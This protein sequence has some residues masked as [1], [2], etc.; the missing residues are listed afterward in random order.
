MALLTFC[1]SSALAKGFYW[2]ASN[3]DQELTLVA[4]MHLAS[5]DFYPLDGAIYQ[6]LKRSELLIL[7][8][9]DLDTKAS[10]QYIQQLGQLG[11]SMRLEE[12][13][14]LLQ[15][16]RAERIGNNLNLP[17]SQV[18]QVK[19]WLYGLI[20]TNQAFDQNGL[21][22]EWGIDKHLNDLANENNIPTASL[23][24][25]KFQVELF[26][27]LPMTAT[28]IDL[29]LNDIEQA[30]ALTRQLTTWWQTSDY[31]AFSNYW[32]SL[33]SADPDY[34]GQLIDARNEKWV[35]QL[36]SSEF[37]KRHIMIVA[38]AGHFPGENGLLAA[39]KK[40]N[41]RLRALHEISH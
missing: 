10:S 33:V 35:K 16:Q 22:A 31:S 41:F 11:P 36:L 34:Y 20:M 24:T 23:E 40:Q 39:L 17:F 21:R 2:Q 27:N 25:F 8:I 5:P 15:I 12:F 30:P 38:G 14:S 13:F 29:L 28:S 4:S 7:E 37:N 19:P 6:H 18:Q 26:N 9:A 32:L 3:N 1:G